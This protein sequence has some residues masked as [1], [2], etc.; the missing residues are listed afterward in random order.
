MEPMLVDR[1][2][3]SSPV[4]AEGAPS[5]GT[6]SLN[7]A[8]K[9]DPSTPS[10]WCAAAFALLIAMKLDEQ[11]LQRPARVPEGCCLTVFRPPGVG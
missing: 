2:V 11:R 1:H 7:R 10:G 4:E 6:D 9:N 3:T 5:H 8:E